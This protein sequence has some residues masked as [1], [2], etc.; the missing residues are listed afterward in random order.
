MSDLNSSSII[1]LMA[2]LKQNRERNRIRVKYVLYVLENGIDEFKM[3]LYFNSLGLKNLFFINI[4]HHLKRKEIFYR[5][6]ARHF[7]QKMLPLK[8][9]VVVVNVYI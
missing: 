7:S 9:V 3:L 6:Y 8:V 4:F 1:F 5:V 2:N